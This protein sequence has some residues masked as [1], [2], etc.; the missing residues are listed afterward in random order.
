[1]RGQEQVEVP[2][3]AFNTWLVEITT[4]QGTQ[5][6]WYQV[7]APHTLVQYDNGTTRMQ[8]VES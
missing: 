6:I 5:S 7:D 1:M 3:G 4:D 8:L 2:A